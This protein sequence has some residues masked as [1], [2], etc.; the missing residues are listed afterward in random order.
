MNKVS[1]DEYLKNFTVPSGKKVGGFMDENKPIKKGTLIIE[2]NII[3]ENIPNK[4]KTKKNLIKH[5]SSKKHN[6]IKN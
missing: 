6:K 1:I 4:N 2:E 3:V 5:N